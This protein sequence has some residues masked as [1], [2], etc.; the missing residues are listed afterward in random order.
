MKI[1][2]RG[3]ASCILQSS[4]PIVAPDLTETQPGKTAILGEILLVFAQPCCSCAD[5]GL[6]AVSHFE[7]VEDIRDMIAHCLGA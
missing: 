5:N 3:S 1:V 2:K 6:C 7:L 4:L